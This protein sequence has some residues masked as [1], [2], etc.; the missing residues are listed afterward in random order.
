MLELETNGHYI[1]ICFCPECGNFVDDSS[2]SCPSCQASLLEDVEVFE[3]ATFGNTLVE[4][5]VFVCSSCGSF[6]GVEATSCCA[7][8]E[9][10]SQLTAKIDFS[11]VEDGLEG[12][13]QSIADTLLESKTA[14]FL[15]ENCGAFLGPGAVKCHICGIEI[16]ESD[17]T[18]LEGDDGEYEADQNAFASD[19]LSSEG[20]LSLCGECGAFVKPDSINCGICGANIE[21]LIWHEDNMEATTADSKLESSGAL[22]I[23]D[24]CGAFMGLNAERCPIC[25]TV[26]RRDTDYIV[27]RQTSSANAPFKG[28]VVAN[29]TERTREDVVEDCRNLYYKK[30]V[31][32]KK[33]GRYKEAIKSLNQTLNLNPEDRI[34]MLEKADIFYEIGKFHRA[35]KLYNHLLESDSEDISIWN[36][37]GNS[38]FRLGHKKESLLCYERALS[39]D[40]N[41][42]EAMINKGFLLMKQGRYVKAIEC[43]EKL[44]G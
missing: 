7:C 3:E 44:I 22:G 35:T 17:G 8:G 33:M 18:D 11:S 13:G 32:L 39:L 36:K 24:I 37:L 2:E 30:A 29:M 4:G 23:C 16:V 40:P 21:E 10:R 41:D 14:L 38:L 12:E 15:C 28:I 34:A 1:E 27:E 25:G 9:K 43:A 5:S 31:A 6:I 42:R 20:E 19:V 26:S